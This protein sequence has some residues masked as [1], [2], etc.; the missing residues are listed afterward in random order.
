MA[1]LSIIVAMDRNRLIG[2]NNE[3][4]WRLP[5]DLQHFKKTTLGKPIIMGRKTWESLGRA[6]PG[7]I[8]IVITRKHDYRAAGAVVVHSL[9]EA[10]SAA[11]DA[12]EAMI[13]GGADLYAQAL[14]A[15]D[16]LYLTRVDGE[17]EGDAWFPQLDEAQWRVEQKTHFEKDDKNE[18]SCEFIIMTRIR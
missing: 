14:P 12:E 8:N 17:F 7:R 2:R 10:L 5:A 15:A 18:F 11:G 13:I 3:L 4:P 6:L 9:H 1:L 16:R